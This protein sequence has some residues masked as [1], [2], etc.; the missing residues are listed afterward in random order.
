L[1]TVCDKFPDLG[2]NPTALRP[3]SY[4][5]YCYE[6]EYCQLNSADYERLDVPNDFSPP[7]I[8]GLAR[9]GTSFLALTLTH[10]KRLYSL[11]EYRT[12]LVEVNP[13]LDLYTAKAPEDTALINY[14]EI[15]SEEALKIRQIA[16]KTQLLIEEKIGRNGTLV[17]KDPDFSFFRTIIDNS[18]GNSKVFEISRPARVAVRSMFKYRLRWDRKEGGFFGWDDNY[19]R[20]FIGYLKTHPEVVEKLGVTGKLEEIEKDP[21]E[22]FYLFYLALGQLMIDWVEKHGQD[23]YLKM[24]YDDF[25]E[26]PRQAFTKI[27]EFFGVEADEEFLQKVTELSSPSGASS[28]GER[29]SAIFS[30]ETLQRVYSA[31]LTRV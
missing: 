6:R 21:H 28:E 23:R 19:K 12:P 20:I 29:D 10:H 5:G 16:Y 25:V 1:D 13:K 24:A 30:E 27:V 17:I 18:F 22:T 15:T 11:H 8:V 14:D 26:K 2:Y 9:C 3:D 31:N 4:V 7:L